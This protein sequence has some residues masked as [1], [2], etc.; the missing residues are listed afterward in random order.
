MGIKFPEF[1][2]RQ[3]SGHPQE[4]LSYLRGDICHINFKGLGGKE[5]STLIEK[6]HLV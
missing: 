4:D 6:S 5:I 2:I 1:I 3:L